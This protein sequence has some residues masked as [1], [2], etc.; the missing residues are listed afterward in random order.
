MDACQPDID[1]F[2]KGLEYTGEVMGCLTEWTKPTDLT[3]KCA[4]TL[5]K[6]AEAPK[7]REKTPEEIEKAKKRRRIR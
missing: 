5:P 7:K 4:A 6:K 3:E 2:C 1:T